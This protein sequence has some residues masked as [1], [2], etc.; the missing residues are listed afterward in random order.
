MQWD[1]SLAVGVDLI[2]DQHQE[3]I[4]RLSDVATALQSGHGFGRIAETLDFLVEY[5]QFHF[6]TE[7]QCM[8]S[9]GYPELEAHAKKH[10][11]LLAT[12]KDVEQE[13]DEE[14]ITPALPGAINT[15]L[16]NW[17]VRHIR[18]VDQ[19]FGEFLKERGIAVAES[20]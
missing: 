4:K 18:E 10:H 14:G 15:L 11:E 20:A 8:A 16:T 5:T 2:D 17:L 7:E 3:W 12:L 9:H 1:N 13:F 19:R 6:G